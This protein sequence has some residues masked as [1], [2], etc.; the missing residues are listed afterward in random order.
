[1]FILLIEGCVKDDFKYLIIDESSK[2]CSSG[3][4][5]KFSRVI[6]RRKKDLGTM[7]ALNP[8]YNEIRVRNHLDEEINLESLFLKV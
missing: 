8:G 4:V 3:T 5:V 7:A 6:A 2:F 1:M